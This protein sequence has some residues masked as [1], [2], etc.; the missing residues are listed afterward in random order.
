MTMLL[1]AMGE[2]GARVS[3]MAYFTVEALKRNE[4]RISIEVTC[5]RK[6]RRILVPTKLGQELR[7]YIEV[8]GLTSG[9]IFC[10]RTGKPMDRR[11]IWRKIQELC[12]KAGVDS[13][14]TSTDCSRG[15]CMSGRTT[16]C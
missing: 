8:M 9:T 2:T 15:W 12:D 11:N 16:S 3:E 10:T 14:T 13:K 7:Q 6:T 4:Q 1:M 5:K